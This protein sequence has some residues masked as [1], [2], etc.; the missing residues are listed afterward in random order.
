M[1]KDKPE[2]PLFDEVVNILAPLE[3]C[4]LEFGLHRNKGLV[5]ADLVIYKKSGVSHDDCQKTSEILLPKLEILLDSQDVNLEVSSPGIS[6]NI[7]TFYELE[8]FVG[9]GV[10]LYLKSK[11][12][13]VNG[14][15]TKN[16]NSYIITKDGINIDISPE[17][18][19]KAKLDDSVGTGR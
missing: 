13:W 8:V 10:S 14:V 12:E 6:R 5:R 19:Q 17:D 1:L 11:S 3:I 4:P 18:I 15:L 16:K 2:H 9:Q 7:K